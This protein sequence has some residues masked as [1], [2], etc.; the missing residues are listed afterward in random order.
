MSPQSLP[1][2]AAPLT[3]A[4]YL[5]KILTARVYDVAHETPLEPARALAGDDIRVVKGVDKG[6]SFFL[7]QFQRVVIGIGVAFAKQHHLAAKAAYRVHL[8][9]RGG[10]GHDDD[11]A[12]AQLAGTQGHALSMV[13]GRRANHPLG[14]LIRR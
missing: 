11:G 13:S 4:D 10:G 6:Q 2:S 9:L 12:G 14:Q 7:L 3:P 1:T 5:K 8:D